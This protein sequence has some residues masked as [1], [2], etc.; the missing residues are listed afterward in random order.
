MASFYSSSVRE[1]LCQ[2]DGETI[3]ALEIGYAQRGFTR[4]FTD[5]TLT[6]E[7][8]LQRLRQVHHRARKTLVEK[9]VSEEQILASVHIAAVVNAAAATLDALEAV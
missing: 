6:W 1:F 9:G 4:H 3:A 7:R 2:S 8:D 5:Q